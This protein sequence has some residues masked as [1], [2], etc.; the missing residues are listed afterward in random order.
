MIASARGG[1][2]GALSRGVLPQ[3][4]GIGIGI[5]ISLASFRR[6]WAVAARWNSSRAPFGPRNR[7]RSSFKDAFEVCEQHLDLFALTARGSVG[8]GFGNFA[9]QVTRPFVDR[10]LDLA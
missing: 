9:G 10:A 3:P 5:G 7:S 2:P 1:G 8:F 4:A 6:F